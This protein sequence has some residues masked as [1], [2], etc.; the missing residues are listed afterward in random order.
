[1]ADIELDVKSEQ[2]SKFLDVTPGKVKGVFGQV[3][4][5][6]LD[7]AE[8]AQILLY[9]QNSGPAKP[10]DSK[11]VRTFDL[12]ASS[13]RKIRNLSPFG[14]QAEWFTDLSYAPF[15]LGKVSQQAPIHRGRWKSLETVISILNRKVGPIT[16]KIL[17][18]VFKK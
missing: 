9:K 18:K 7:V 6:L 17:N 11:Y 2:V 10:P 14:F 8:Q 15:V 5:L 1:M 13:E 16:K 12:Q 3:A 4:T